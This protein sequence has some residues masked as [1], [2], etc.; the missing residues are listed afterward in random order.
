MSI[1]QF[2]PVPDSTESTLLAPWYMQVARGLV[3]GASVVNVYGYTATAPH[4]NFGAVWEGGT[5]AYAFPPAA[6]VPVYAS[7]SSETLTMLVSGV[8]ASYSPVSTTVTFSGGTAGTA[9]PSQSFLRI[10]SMRLLTGANVGTITAQI[11]G[12][13]YAQIAPTAGITQ[14]SVYTVPLGYTFYLTK[15]QLYS[16]NNGSQY[17]TYRVLTNVAGTGPQ[18]ALL[19]SP[20]STDYLSLRV[21]PRGYAQRTDIQWQVQ[22]TGTGN[23]VGAQIEGILI[24]NTAA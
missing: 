3:P 13:T 10:N 22:N 4:A 15:A 20:F 23:A 6:G 8:D 5:T 16:N 12:V 21:A 18:V 9:S 14:M 11:S 19:N 24:A 2:P 17:T 1:T 7:T